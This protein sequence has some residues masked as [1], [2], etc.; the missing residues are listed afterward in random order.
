MPFILN[1]TLRWSLIVL[2]TVSCSFGRRSDVCEV[3]LKAALDIGSGTTKAVLARLAPCEERPITVVWEESRALAL[4]EDLT[5]HQKLSDQVLGQAA[6]VVNELKAE[7]TA[8]QGELVAAVATMAVREAPNGLDWAQRLSQLA[9]INVRVISQRDEALLGALSAK[10]LRPDV[11]THVIWDIGGASSQWIYQDGIKTELE[12]SNL[13]SV[14]LKNEVIRTL[15]RNSKTPNP[16][17]REGVKQTQTLV[18]AHV[19]R[20]SPELKQAIAKSRGVVLGVGGVHRYSVLGQLKS[21]DQRYDQG[22]LMNVI[23]ARYKLSDEQIGGEYAS[24]DVT[25]LVLVYTAMR[26][27]GV[28]VVEVAP[29]NLALGAVVEN[30]LL[31]ANGST[32]THSSP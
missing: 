23:R 19:A 31:N 11:K 17:G 18:R 14:S 4:K 20:Y 12:L 28:Q 7:I 3:S 10:T 6:Q 22:A 16:L 15:K 27:L 32:R 9:K 2:I 26:D 13:A 25:N 30:T 29:G 8:R 5:K 21:K 24:T 1:S